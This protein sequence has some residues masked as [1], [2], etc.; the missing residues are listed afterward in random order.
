LINNEDNKIL[1]IN[2]SYSIEYIGIGKIPYFNWLHWHD[3]I[4]EGFNCNYNLHEFRNIY[5]ATK[6]K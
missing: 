4:K 5:A 6:H 3:E 2:N 1:S